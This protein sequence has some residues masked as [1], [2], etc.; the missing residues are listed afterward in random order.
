MFGGK[1]AGPDNIQPLNPAG[2]Q[3]CNIYSYREDYVHTREILKHNLW[4]YLKTTLIIYLNLGELICHLLSSTEGVPD[5]L[6]SQ[7]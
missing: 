4:S 5:S 7:I 3:A 1:H 2:L 6:L